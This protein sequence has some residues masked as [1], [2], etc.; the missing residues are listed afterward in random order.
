MAVGDPER[1]DEVVQLADEEVDRP[2]VGAAVRVVRAAAVAELV[3]VDDG[4]AV[5]EVGEREEVVVRRAGAAVE[6]DERR[7]RS[8]VAGPQVAGHAVPGLRLVEGDA[9]PSRTSTCA[10]LRRLS[11]PSTGSTAACVS[12]GRRWRVARH[13]HRRHAPDAGSGHFRRPRHTRAA[14]AIA[15]SVP[16][17]PRS[18]RTGTSASGQP[19]M[20]ALE[21]LRP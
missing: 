2:E 12:G 5:G 6:D 8:G 17:G 18:P 19:S 3:V 11:T 21:E 1:V 15:P 10:T 13:W 14:T 4:A 9:V 20:R 7:G 16:C